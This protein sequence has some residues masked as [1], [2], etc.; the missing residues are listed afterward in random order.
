MAARGGATRTAGAGE[1]N[2][3]VLDRVG[4]AHQAFLSGHGQ[5]FRLDKK[6]ALASPIW[7]TPGPCDAEDLFQ[8][9]QNWK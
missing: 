8:N 5:S 2:R 3:L 4:I 9:G 1:E 7:E 6:K